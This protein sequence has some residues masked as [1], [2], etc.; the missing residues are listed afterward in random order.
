M[1]RFS[2]FSQPQSARKRIFPL[3]G[4]IK[5]ANRSESEHGAWETRDPRASGNSL[6]D[7]KLEQIHLPVGQ[8]NFVN[9]KSFRFVQS[10]REKYSASV[11]HK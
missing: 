9:P 10:S 4:A 7:S 3:K 1:D 5:S 6:E 2:T 11:F 8:I